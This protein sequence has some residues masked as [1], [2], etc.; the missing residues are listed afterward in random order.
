VAPGK[1]VIIGVCD[2]A[3]TPTPESAPRRQI[4]RLSEEAGRLERS[5]Y[6][7]K[8]NDRITVAFVDE[9]TLTRECITR[10]LEELD[11]TLDVIS[12]AGVADCLQSAK[13]YHSILYYT[14]ATD[15]NRYYTP[16]QRFEIEALVK[17]APV[18]ILSLVDHYDAIVEGLQIG[19]QAFIPVASTTSKQVIEIIH[20][21][22]AGGMYVP[23]SLYLQRLDRSGPIS[24]ATETCQFSSR[25]WEVLELLMQGKA[26][27]TIAFE[28]EVS[29]S[30]IKA[31]IKSIMSRLKATNRTEAVCRAYDLRGVGALSR[32]EPY[33]AAADPAFRYR[34]PGS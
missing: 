30:T 34:G 29:E 9:Y 31:Y 6:C 2:H 22:K 11:H 24:P 23:A 12:F 8:K 16:K 28:L 20:L 7:S 1:E 10:L 14:P 27:K 26:N 5:S 21:V 18:I 13:F 17:F 15:V 33:D 19:A 25:E 32:R 4:K 3:S